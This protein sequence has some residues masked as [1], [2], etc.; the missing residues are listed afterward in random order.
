VF[1][2]AI[3]MAKLLLHIYFNNRYGY[4]RDEFDYIACGNHLAWGFV[5]QPP[6]IPFLVRVSRAA[7]GDSLRS[8]RLVPAVASS[9]LVVQSALIAREL[10]GRRF[11][12]VLSAVAV[13]LA[14]MYLSDGSLLTTNCLEPNLWMGCVYLAILAV[15]RADPRYWLWFGVIAGIGLEEKYAIALFGFAIVIGLL[16]TNERRQ[17]ANRW[18][19]LGGLVAFLIFLPNVLWNLYHHWPFLQLMHSI[20]VEHRDVVLSAGQY[21]FQEALLIG[22][23]VAPLWI[24]GLIALFA[25]ARWRHFRFLAWSFI[26]CYAVLFALHGKIY[27]L[28]PAYPMLLS[29]G[30]VIVESF[31]ERPT[32]TWLAPAT[33]TVLVAAGLSFAPIMVPIL[34]PSSFINYMNHLPFKLPVTEYSHERADLPQWYADQFGWREIVAETALA[35]NKIPLQ[36]RASCAVF[37]QNYGQAGAIDFFGPDYGLPPALSGHQTCFLWGPRGYSGNCMIVLDDSV[38]RLSQ[39]YSSV[40]YVGTSTDNRYALEKKIDVFICRGAKFGSLAQLWPSIKKWS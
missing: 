18:T 6:L 11:A 7:F 16:L 39:L 17:L 28:A 12:L 31:V 4:F 1:V 3:A 19:W 21:F 29:A 2:S 38:A 23:P 20:R 15:K 32:R 5:D 33:L 9:L 25:S 10:G 26:I 22:L 13:A 8:I 37:A 35:W 24:T 27:Y 40:Q 30:A 14:P 34:S 36:E